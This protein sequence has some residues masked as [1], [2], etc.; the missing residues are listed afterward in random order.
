MAFPS[1]ARASRRPT[2]EENEARVRSRPSAGFTAEGDTLS[3]RDTG[4]APWLVH[5]HEDEVKERVRG[6]KCRVE[7]RVKDGKWRLVGA[8]EEVGD[9][10]EKSFSAL[11]R[12]SG[13]RAAVRSSLMR[14]RG[15]DGDAG[16]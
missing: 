11:G 3:I 12:G 5:A 13:E 4:P 9:R 15:K 8:V 2:N 16:G 14:R 7:R 10:F 6:E 1:L